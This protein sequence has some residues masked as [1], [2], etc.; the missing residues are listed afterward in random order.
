MVDTGAETTLGEEE[1]TCL[2]AARAQAATKTI[3]ASPTPEGGTEEATLGGEINPTTTE[4]QL[5][6]MEPLAII[7]EGVEIITTLR[8]NS[9]TCSIHRQYSYQRASSW[10]S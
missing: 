4:E 1:P 5:P 3:P 9:K 7:V 2:L 6:L 8:T 10:R